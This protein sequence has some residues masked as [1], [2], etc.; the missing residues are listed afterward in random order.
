MVILGPMSVDRPPQPLGALP[1]SAVPS[2]ASRVRFRRAVT[3]LGMTVA[4]PGSAQLVAGSARIG[5]IALRVYAGVVVCGLGFGGL[6]LFWRTEL[7]SLFTSLLL[8][9]VLRFGLIALALGWAY[10]IID[11]WRIADPLGLARRQRLMVT[12]LNGVLCFSVTGVLLFASHLVAVQR[13]FIASVFSG[14]EVTAAEHGRYNV[15][16]LGGDAGRDRVGIRPDSIT[17]AS[18]DEDTG[19]TVLLGVPRNLADVPFPEGTTM[20]E[21]FPDGFDC[22]GCYLNGVNTWATDNADLFPHVKNPGI[23]ATTEAVE[24]ITGLTMNYYALI[25]LKGFQDLV[26]AVGGVTIDVGERIPVGGVGGPITDYIEP[27]VQHL[28]GFQTLWY[29]RSRATSDDYSR[30]ARQKCVMNAMLHQLDAKTLL[31]N[32]GDIAKAGKQIIST[33]IP[34]SELDTFI[35]LSL[36]TK[37]LPVSSVSFVPPK[38][39]TGDPDWALIKTMVTEAIEKSEA[40]DDGTAS[41]SGH[42]KKHHDANDSSDLS[43]SC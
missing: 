26:E 41:D 9:A 14:D 16:L 17:V 4:A 19:R 7:V 5:R 35:N 31:T 15:L 42:N 40:R 37:D 24:E 6:V 22:E 39:N 3:L 12:A 20:H 1:H 28:N 25:D 43:N 32:F 2:A 8:L 34:A 23:V 30:M 29:A 38:I 21:Q 11:A 18:I 10:L 36:K 13:D 33:S 27:G